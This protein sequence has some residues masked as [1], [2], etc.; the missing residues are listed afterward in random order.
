MSPLL[1]VGVTSSTPN[2]SKCVTKEYNT[3]VHVYVHYPTRVSLEQEEYVH[4]TYLCGEVIRSVQP[5]DLGR[6]R[7]CVISVYVSM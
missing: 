7:V 6:T 5:Q 4:S 3:D 1:R 2:I